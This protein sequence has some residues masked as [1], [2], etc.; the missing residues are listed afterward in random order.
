MEKIVSSAEKKTCQK[1][2]KLFLG[3]EHGEL[4]QWLYIIRGR[5]VVLE[6][7]SMV[8]SSF[9]ILKTKGT[10]ICL[11]WLAS[12]WCGGFALPVRH[13]FDEFI[14]LLIPFDAKMDINFTRQ[15]EV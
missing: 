6:R 5:F 13:K 12:P 9:S 8:L 1:L 14:R 15:K 7:I 10:L 2:T 4:Q 3:H 11:T